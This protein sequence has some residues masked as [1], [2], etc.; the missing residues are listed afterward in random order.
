VEKPDDALGGIKKLFGGRGGRK[1]KAD[2]LPIQVAEDECL[3]EAENMDEIKD[4]KGQ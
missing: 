4:C 2:N 3:A 1:S